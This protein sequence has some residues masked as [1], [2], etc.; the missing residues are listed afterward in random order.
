MDIVERNQLHEILVDRFSIDEI[1]T[2]CFEL[3]IEYEELDGDGRTGKAR[4][5]ITYVERRGRTQDLIN[6]AKIARPEANW[7]TVQ[8]SQE[9][10]RLVNI[11]QQVSELL[12]Q[13]TKKRLKIVFIYHHS[14]RHVAD[15]LLDGLLPSGHDL[16]FAPFGL[17]IGSEKWQEVVRHDIESAD[18]TLL[19]DTDK[20]FGDEWVR[21]R[22]ML[23]M[24]S[25][26]TFIPVKLRP[27]DADF[28][29]EWAGLQS[30]YYAVGEE[31]PGFFYHL[32]KEIEW[33]H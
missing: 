16:V 27:P 28:P 26:A 2:L 21:W 7:P 20:A 32:L 22:V 23:A 9:K 15:E 6:C 12:D 8:P 17:A 31:N 25:K 10:G 4:E 3:G 5:L 33:H 18:V 13:D 30:I 29:V 19:L 11:K 1:R 14:E 24:D